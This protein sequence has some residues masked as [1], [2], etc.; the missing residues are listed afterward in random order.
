MIDLQTKETGRTSLEHLQRAVERAGH[1]LPV[2]GPIG[3]FV[4]HNTLH[5]FQHLPF[6]EAVAEA[7]KFYGCQPY[8]TEAAFREELGRGR[9]LPQDVEAVLAREDDA[10]ILP[11]AVLTRRRL[12]RLLLAPGLRNF[13][14]RSLPWLLEEGG[15]LDDWRDDLPPEARKALAHD[16]PADLWKTCRDLTPAAAAREA[17]DF[18]RPRDLVL[19]DTGLDTDEIVHPLLV[20]LCGAFLDQ[21]IAYWPMPGRERGLLAASRDLLLANPAVCPGELRG[22]RQR[23]LSQ[24]A[25]ESRAEEIV[26]GI[27]EEF[28]VS[29]SKYGEVVAST[30]LAL[31]GWAGMIRVLEHD[32]EL[33]PHVRLP[34]SLMDFLALRLTLDAAALAGA[35][36]GR[37][38]SVESAAPSG[39]RG[40]RRLERTALLF[41]A[42]Q[43][44]G[45]DSA[46]L[47]GLAPDLFQRLVDELRTFDGLQRRRI[48]H[49]AYERRHE[50]E[51]LVPLATHRSLPPLEPAGDRL[52][53]QV[54]FCIDDREE[55]LR[56]HLEEVDPLIETYGAAGFYGVAIDYHGIDEARAVALCP[57]VV[58]PGHAVAEA[59]VP[60]H[61]ELH[62]RRQSLRRFWAGLVRGGFVSSR[63]LVRGWISTA[64]LGF[65]SIFPL[66]ARVLS[67]L[68]YSRFVRWLNRLFLPEPRTE[69]A[70]MRDDAQGREAT[71]G[72]LRGFG[73]EEKVERVANV[74]SGAGLVRGMARLVIVLGHGSTSLN[75]PHESAYDCGACGGRSGG[76][77]ARLFAAMANLPAVREGLRKKGVHIPE[78]TWFVGG[79]HDTCRDEIDLYDLDRLPSDHAG[80]LDRLCAAFDEARA[81]NALERT[82][83][84]EAAELSLSPAG[85]LRHVQE[86]AEHLAEPR[87]E[88][89][90]STN[91]VAVVGRRRITRGLF[92]DRRAFLVSYDA[93]KDPSDEALGRLLGAVVPVCAGISLEY[94]FSTVDNERLGCGTKLPHNITG[95]VGV[96]DGC[97]SDLRTGLNW[98]MVEIHEPVRIQFVVETT[99]ERLSA[100]VAGNPELTE[101]VENRWVRLAAIGPDSGEIQVYRGNG[102][103][104]PL[105]EGGEALPT[106]PTSQSWYQGRRGHLPLAR[107]GDVNGSIG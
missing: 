40:D 69:L 5:A 20:R 35:R 59:P 99:P 62:R 103:W 15:W 73:T 9:I 33:A 63:T 25:A 30:L 90:H 43:L 37:A 23:F 71:E 67:P 11:A 51:V 102:V 1:L 8:L 45:L 79:Y 26:L 100:V 60:E 47:R 58:K 54:F 96:M 105:E 56:R 61:A 78:D 12:R 75:N 36:K 88:Y 42:A 44:A 6:H 83:R 18:A 86:R 65:L 21:G 94:Y 66:A 38:E 48:L 13:D 28:G 14:A 89:G 106:A 10:E 17:A 85:G 64:T 24:I 76:P 22:L 92:L 74:L 101:L 68:A 82:R 77:N 39:R 50:R 49:L 97:Q 81:R 27:L 52:A 93:T 3:V 53:A 95:L 2:Q 107:I 104:E 87:P 29:P 4:H 41:E 31:P 7:S 91:A 84:F 98:Q 70:F 32:P 46:T 55:S 34:C 19:R 72:L 80:D 16:S 57:V